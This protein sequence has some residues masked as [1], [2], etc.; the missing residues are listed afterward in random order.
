MSTNNTFKGSR[1]KLLFKQA[2]IHNNKMMLYSSVGFCGVVFLILIFSQLGNDF[3][4]HDAEMFLGF[5]TGFVAVFGILYSGYSF[6]AFRSKENTISYLTL[7]ASTFEKFLFEFTSRI[8][9]MLIA[10]PFLFWLTF[11]FEGYV[12]ELFGG[13]DFNPVGISDLMKTAPFSEAVPSWAY[14]LMTF[15][16][17]LVF[18][19]PFTGAAMYSKQPLVKTLFSLAVVIVFFVTYAYIV[20]EPLGL[21][22]YEVDNSVM[23]LIPRS[24]SGALKFASFLVFIANLTML[25]VAYFKLKEKEV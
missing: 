8:I 24:E 10:L 13:P 21:G 17:F 23:W 20:I 5:L 6:P 15:S 12:F 19:L 7:P 22:K 1:F 4:P 18:V 9:I 14:V 2:A 25:S 11:N 16:S 3:R